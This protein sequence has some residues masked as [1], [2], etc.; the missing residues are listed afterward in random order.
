MPFA[1]NIHYRRSSAKSKSKTPLLLIH[2]AGGAYLSWSSELRRL[3][4]NDVLAIDL[5]GHGDSPGESMGSIGAYAD[6]VLNFLDQLKI[7]QV[8]LSGHSMG[9]AIAMQLCLD[10][11]ERVAGLI[12]VGSGAKYEVNP[13]LIEYCESD[14]TYPHAL[15]LIIKFSFSQATDKRLVELA[16]K[17]LAETPPKIL[18]ADFIACDRFEISN[19][20]G[21]INQPTLVICGEED[22]MMPVSCSK[23]LTEGIPKSR[24]E[25]VPAAGHMVMLERPEVVA[26]LVLEFL[27]EIKSRQNTP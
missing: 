24:L 26:Q 1:G 22:R 7:D 25:I 27:T 14:I 23:M 19:Q 20:L 8:V 5:P 4:G 6:E 17:R 11:P 3:P 2:G 10:Q 9:G 12:L 15:D 18:Q 13:K 16:A 21:E